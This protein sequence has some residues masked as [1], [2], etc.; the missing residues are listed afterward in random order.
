M[1]EELMLWLIATIKLATALMAVVTLI[2][3]VDSCR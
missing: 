3:V 1:L 2:A